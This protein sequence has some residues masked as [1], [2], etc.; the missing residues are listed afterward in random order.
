MGSNG[1][2]TPLR[3]RHSLL[4]R[5]AQPPEPPVRPKQVLVQ[6]VSRPQPVRPQVRSVL[7]DSADLLTTGSERVVSGHHAD[8]ERVDA[9]RGQ[10][11][12]Q[13]RRSME[14]PD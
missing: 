1:G 5:E 7:P 14:R 13:V 10:V 11:P 12:E 2:A 6:G 9:V 3:A 8:E 4:E